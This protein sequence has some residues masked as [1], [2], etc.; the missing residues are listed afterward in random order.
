MSYVCVHKCEVIFHTT[1]LCDPPCIVLR[2]V[3]VRDNYLQIIDNIQNADAEVIFKSQTEGNS[4]S[5]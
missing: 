3:Q 1:A 5:M 4:S 2:F